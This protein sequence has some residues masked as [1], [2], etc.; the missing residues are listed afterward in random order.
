M[1]HHA[2]SR[3]DYLLTTDGGGFLD[4]QLLEDSLHPHLQ[5]VGNKMRATFCIWS[6]RASTDKQ[7]LQE[8]LNLLKGD[9]TICG[10]VFQF[11]EIHFI[12]YTSIKAI[13]I[14]TTNHA[15]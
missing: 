3:R 2:T 12:G 8:L 1:S 11:R 6:P 9:S 10:I 7:S 13:G 15:R 5:V 14:T 4:N